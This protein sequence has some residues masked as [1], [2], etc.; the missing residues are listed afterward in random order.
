MSKIKEKQ[1]AQFLQVAIE[2]LEESREEI[3]NCYGRDTSFTDK[4]SS[5]L[6]LAEINIKEE[7]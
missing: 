1:L 5:F 7:K 2:L 3:Q 4:I 6:L